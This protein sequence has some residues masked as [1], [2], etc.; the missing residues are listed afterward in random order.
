MLSIGSTFAGKYEIVALL[1]EGSFGRVYKGRQLSTGQAVAIKVL[2]FWE[3]DAPGNV[4]NQIARFRREMRLCAGL[5]HTNV[6]RLIDSGESEQGILYAVFEY[7]PGV[8]L[9]K[10]LDTEGKLGMAE[11]LHLLTQVLDALS[12]A[13]AR[14]V[15]HRD[16]KPE[17]ILITRTG[18]RRN[19]LV[20]DLG[21]GGFTRE[22]EG[23]AL[24]RITATH[25]LMGTP[26]YA[27]PEQLRGEPPSPRSDL[28]S[29]GL[30]CLEC[31]T[32]EVAV[33]GGSSPDVILKQ[34][35]PDPVPIA[36]W[37]R[38]QRLGRLLEVLTAKEVERRDLT[39]ERLLE[40]LSVIQRGAMPYVAGGARGEQLPATERRLTV[41]SCRM[42]A[43]RLDPEELR[44][45]LG[46][47]YAACSEAIDQ[48]DGLIAQ[49]LGDGILAYFG[50]PRVHEDN[51]QRAVLA[52]LAIQTALRRLAPDVAARHGIELTARVG[53]HTGGVVILE[54]P[55][56]RP[57]TQAV[58][59]AIS[60]AAHVQAA[61]EPGAVL[62]T[63]DTQRL[64]AGSFMVA[65]G[66]AQPIEGVPEPITLY[67]VERLVGVRSRLPSPGLAP[68]VGRMQ[69]R[70]LLMERWG[71]AR[72]GG[73]QV[74]LL[75][76]EPGIG[77]SRLVEQFRLD[78]GGTPHTWVAVGASRYEQHTPFALIRSLFQRAFAWP[79]D[80][81]AAD[82]LSQ[83]E[84]TL[85]VGGPLSAEAAPLLAGLLEV[86]VGDR[87][88]PLL[89]SPE[90]RRRK[91]IAVLVAKVCFLAEQQPLVLALDD[92]QWADPSTLETLGLLAGQ[93]A[94]VPIVML[95]TARP[96]LR[97][98][99]PARGD[100][101][102]ITLSGLSRQELRE[103]VAGVMSCVP[104]DDVLEV[105][106]KRTD[107]VPLF[108]EELARAV[109]GE[110]TAALDEIPV[111]LQDS[112]LAR[113]DR[114]GPAKDVAQVASVLGREFPYVLLR[115]VAGLS[116]MQLEASLGALTE[117]EL[118]YARGLPP[119]ATY[120]FKHA[121][122]QQAAYD[123]LLKRP[124]RELHAR[125]AEMLIGRVDGLPE[126][127][128]EVI[129]QHW[130]AAGEAERAVAAWQ[131]AG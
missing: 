16:L 2:R 114:L 43:G 102:Q 8:T 26:C 100:S 28:Y 79:P 37:L 12:C 104:P 111:S 108:A 129:A 77:K 42:V 32:G 125:V 14:G 126:P 78:L 58:G 29:W 48:Y 15:V 20:L 69:E 52:G 41:L 59:D 25:E 81:P 124:R 113:I 84:I 94:A 75:T 27:A 89:M 119:H 44:E 17:N 110:H 95:L 116:D 45:I 61:A 131:E 11:T 3:G 122:V 9:R 38:E 33:G 101:I 4:E 67:R 74:V 96:E 103:L 109:V 50:Y 55:G 36:S 71:R 24:P 65:E 23:W 46:A 18:A 40:E 90:Q 1:G 91:L 118:L 86:P 85:G 49:H 6:V 115:A 60:I 21:L 99:W 93:V 117:A 62:I 56:A 54:I 120:V 68:F 34:L 19:A 106:A 35:G 64:V 87:Y 51:A 70:R 92:L 76:G 107:G 128:P 88:P 66:S 47:Y 30:I 121:L 53:L 83:I 72:E 127:P 82:R 63:A 22:A 5:W 112:L 123:S 13:H 73:G 130:T 31:L 97:A 10:V 80:L 105:L 39:I 57:E 98:P 7:V